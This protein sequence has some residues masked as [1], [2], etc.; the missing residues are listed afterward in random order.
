M[1]L[2]AAGGRRWGWAAVKGFLFAV[3]CCYKSSQ[4]AQ[5]RPSTAPQQGGD[6][7]P[8]AYS[9][10]PPNPGVCLALPWPMGMFSVT[11]GEVPAL[12]CPSSTQHWGTLG[13]RES[14]RVHPRLWL[15]QAPQ[16]PSS[17]WCS[18]YWEHPLLSGFK[19]NL[20]LVRIELN[21]TFFCASG[22]L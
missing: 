22:M 5:P 7:F 9:R 20:V 18:Q 21:P 4:E 19:T 14:F 1:V 10:A 13:Y 17:P 12:V 2:P 16:S 11:P 3:S 15:P 8:A 6:Q